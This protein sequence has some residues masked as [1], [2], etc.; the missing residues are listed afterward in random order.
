MLQLVGS[1]A[2]YVARE[3]GL[4]PRGKALSVTVILL[5]LKVFAMPW[6]TEWVHPNCRVSC[7]SVFMTKIAIRHTIDMANL[8]I[9]NSL[10]LLQERE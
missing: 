4:D 3:A 6:T 1:E 9:W 8:D 5:V 10:E 7:H 2:V